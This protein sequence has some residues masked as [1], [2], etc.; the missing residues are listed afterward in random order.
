[1]WVAPS[2]S[3]GAQMEYKGKKKMPTSTRMSLLC[4]LAAVR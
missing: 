3:L 4:F 2:S 1:M